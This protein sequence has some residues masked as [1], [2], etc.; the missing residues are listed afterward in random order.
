MNKEILAMLDDIRIANKENPSS[1][2]SNMAA[3]TQLAHQELGL[4]CKSYGTIALHHIKDIYPTL[5][6]FLFAASFDLPGFPPPAFSL[7][8]FELP[9]FEVPLFGDVCTPKN[10]LIS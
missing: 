6:I 7:L 3:M 8:V 4:L 5:E 10:R 2:S 9:A 1:K